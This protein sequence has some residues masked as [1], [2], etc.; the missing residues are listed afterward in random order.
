VHLDGTSILSLYN[1]YLLSTLPLH[2][3]Q[4]NPFSRQH[5]DEELGGY[6]HKLTAKVIAPTKQEIWD[7]AEEDED[8]QVLSQAIEAFVV[9]TRAGCKRTATSKVVDNAVQARDAKR[10]KAS[11]SGRK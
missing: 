8:D 10:A 4:A 5:S 7:M 1:T 11:H 6:V 3:Y 9:P 2:L